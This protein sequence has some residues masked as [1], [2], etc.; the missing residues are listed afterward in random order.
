MSGEMENTR[1]EGTNRLTT[2]E[3]IAAIAMLILMVV[4]IISIFYVPH[5]QQQIREQKSEN[6][7][8]RER[9][10]C[11]T[12]VEAFDEY[13]GTIDVSKGMSMG[14]VLDLEAKYLLCYHVTNIEKYSEEADREKRIVDILYKAYE[15]EKDSKNK[16][17]IKE[18]LGGHEL[19][20]D[21]SQKE[22]EKWRGLF[23][24]YND[25]LNEIKEEL[26]ETEEQSEI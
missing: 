13:I 23:N 16:E 2:R 17:V 10:T 8:L 11:S 4:G 21:N 14:E 3:I 5:L 12:S 22:L 1:N 6:L 26:D 7:E 15:S 9:L 25:G 20:L 18:C 19:L 24:D